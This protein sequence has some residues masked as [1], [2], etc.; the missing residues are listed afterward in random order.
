[1]VFIKKITHAKL[2]TDISVNKE[3]KLDPS[4]FVPVRVY[5]AKATKEYKRLLNKNHDLTPMEFDNWMEYMQY[6]KKDLKDIYMPLVMLQYDPHRVDRLFKVETPEGEALGV[7][8]YKPP[9][10]RFTEIEKPVVNPKI[11][12]YLHHLF[13]KEEAFN[14]MMESL[15][16]VLNDRLQVY[17]VLN[18]KTGVGK[19]IFVENLVKAMVGEDNYQ[20]APATWAKSG[21]NVWLQDKQVILFDEA[22]IQTE[23]NEENV[24]LLKRI[25]NETQAI[26]RK[27]VDVEGN[28]KNHASFFICSNNDTKNFRL[29]EDNRRF[30]PIDITDIKLRDVIGKEGIDELIKI[31]KDPE[32][33]GNF[34]WW[35]QKEWAPKKGSKRD[36]TTVFKGDKYREFQINSL[37]NWKCFLVETITSGDFGEL[38]WERANGDYN[39]WRLDND[40]SEIDSERRFRFNGKPHE[41]EIFIKS[42]RYE[43]AE[44]KAELLGTYQWL[45]RKNKW[46]IQVNP[47]FVQ[48]E[49]KKQQELAN[50]SLKPKRVT[51]EEDIL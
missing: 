8:R 39:E 51:A 12:Q 25:I 28:V 18:G 30:S 44:G 15:W 26:E 45:G 1:M 47:I 11:L 34:Y 13:P 19:G 40:T 41:V 22:K 9:Q 27:G 31:L 2:K 16:Y 3:K 21:F 42:F 48:A 35:I 4:E 17:I 32:E 7:N 29:E 33:I 49:G 20:T 24:N 14:F 46:C 5:D 6:D 38:T 36:A 23:G 10:H 43:F 50:M 37:K